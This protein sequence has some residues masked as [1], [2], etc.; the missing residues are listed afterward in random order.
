M[1]I[2]DILKAYETFKSHGLDVNTLLNARLRLYSKGADDRNPNRNVHSFLDGITRQQG[3][4]KSVADLEDRYP[5]YVTKFL[6]GDT[7]K[8]L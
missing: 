3:E 8:Q 6:H 2:T 7:R 1:D 5:K 4:D